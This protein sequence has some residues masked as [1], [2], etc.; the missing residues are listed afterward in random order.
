MPTL[1]FGNF[2]DFL[3]DRQTL[4]WKFE[5]EKTWLG[6][7]L[8][9]GITL[10]S[11][12]VIIFG[13]QKFMANRKP[14][15]ANGLIIAHNWFLC[16]FSLGLF[17]LIAESVFPRV[18]KNGL[19]WGCCSPESIQQD[20]RLEFY[21]Y[22]NYLGKFYELLDTV[23]L[24]LRKKK[25][26]FLHVYHHSLTLLLCYTQLIGNNSVQW[27]PISINLV[28]HVL[29]YYYFAR[30]AAGVQIWW[31]KYLTTM[32]IIQFV[33]DMIAVYFCLYT[34]HTFRSLYGL[35][36]EMGWGDCHGQLWSGWVGAF[37]LTSYLWLFVDFY[38]KTY[39]TENTGKSTPG[40]TPAAKP[41]KSE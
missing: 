38:N 25:L 13:L 22:L 1:G 32:Q 36:P 33:L 28:V 41:I 23:F 19:I 2:Y 37:L 8:E 14:I 40:E 16:L 30:A 17:L 4:Y 7:N 3:M 18:W 34:W 31:K 6:S 15:H 39:R 21:Y 12:Y 24:V 26:E 9:V 11:Y 20:T 35:K 27:V 5:Q 10:I 29:M